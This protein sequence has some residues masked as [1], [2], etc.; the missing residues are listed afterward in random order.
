MGRAV[1]RGRTESIQCWTGVHCR[2]Y[3][4]W[5]EIFWQAD[6]CSYAEAADT[7]AIMRTL[8]IGDVSMQRLH[9]LLNDYVDSLQSIALTDQIDLYQWPDVLFVAMKW[10]GGVLLLA[11]TRGLPVERPVT[12]RTSSIDII[13]AMKASYQTTTEIVLTSPWNIMHKHWIST[14]LKNHRI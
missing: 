13:N 1:E 8:Q 11:P 4:G 6:G 5:L 9:K 10:R 14:S 12:H 2:W 7:S 3:W